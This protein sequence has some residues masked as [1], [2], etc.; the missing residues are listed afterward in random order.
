MKKK[1][2]IYKISTLLVV[3]LFCGCGNEEPFVQEASN[4]LYF[5]DKAA[6]FVV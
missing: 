3:L 6:T 4:Q 2:W 1:T 5:I